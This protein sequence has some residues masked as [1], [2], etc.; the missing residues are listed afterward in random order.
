MPSHARELARHFDTEGTPVMIG[1]GALAYT[2]LGVAFH[3]GTGE[4]RFLILDPHYTG[5]DE[6]DTIQGKVGL[7]LPGPRVVRPD[8]GCHPSPSRRQW[9]WKATVRVR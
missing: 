6:L 2:L 4:A 1:G 7:P 9:P 3:G 8:L 5:P